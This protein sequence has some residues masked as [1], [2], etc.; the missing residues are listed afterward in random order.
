MTRLRTNFVWIIDVVFTPGDYFA[1]R[2]RARNVNGWGGYSP[3]SYIQ[4]A[5]APSPPDQPELK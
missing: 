5:T 1:F 3:I 2:Y 4:A